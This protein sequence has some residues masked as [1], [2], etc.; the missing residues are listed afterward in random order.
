MNFERKRDRKRNGGRC[1]EERGERVSKT[2]VWNA[3]V[4]LEPC[5]SVNVIF[6]AYL[7]KRHSPV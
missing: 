1:G 4:P 7:H 2:E 5:E 3:N 6:K